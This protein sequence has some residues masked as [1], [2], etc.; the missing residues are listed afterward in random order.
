MSKATTILKVG[1]RVRISKDSQ[2]YR[3]VSSESNPRN[4]TGTITFI[5]TAVSYCYS[6]KWDNGKSNSYPKGD[7]YLYQEIKVGDRV[8]LSKDSE[9]YK[10]GS[11]YSNPTDVTGTVSEVREDETFRYRVDWDNGGDNSYTEGDLYLYSEKNKKSNE[12]TVSKEFVLEAYK[13][14]CSDWK[15][16]LEQEFPELFEA[17]KYPTLFE[18]KRG[19][20]LPAAHLYVKVRDLDGKDKYVPL[21]GVQIAD[22]IAD[23]HNLPKE[24]KHKALYINQDVLQFGD[25]EVKQKRINSSSHA[26]YFEK[27]R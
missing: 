24:A 9:Y 17:D 8:R 1:D 2:Y 27:K 25:Y 16:K 10:D 6:V 12:L 19:E 7:L 13:S 4:V 5:D 3:S 20:E 14:A 15:M 21:K 22:G 18:L 23:G 11:F 26:V